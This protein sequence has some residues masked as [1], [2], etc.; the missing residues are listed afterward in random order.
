[1]AALK[2]YRLLNP[3]P[4]VLTVNTVPLPEPPPLAAVPNR[5][6]PDKVNPACGL[7]PSLLVDGLPEVAVKLCRVVKVWAGPQPASKTPSMNIAKKQPA[8]KRTA[9]FSEWFSSIIK[10]SFQ[11]KFNSQR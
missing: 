9:R 8:R 7:A 6:L 1:M 2:A 10:A 5:V 11:L 4:L 3:V